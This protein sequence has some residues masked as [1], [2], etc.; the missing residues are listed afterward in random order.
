VNG[1]AIAPEEN[2]KMGGAVCVSYGTCTYKNCVYIQKDGAP[3]FINDNW[4]LAKAWKGTSYGENVYY[5][6]SIDDFLAGRNG[7][8]STGI[9]KPRKSI[10]RRKGLP[11]PIGAKFGNLTKKKCILVVRKRI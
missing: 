7:F 5:Y 2:L 1:N 9:S 11:M 4:N 10:K 6:A 3:R 8:V